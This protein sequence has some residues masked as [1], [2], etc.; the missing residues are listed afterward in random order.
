MT[1][2]SIYINTYANIL[3][4]VL[5]LLHN[6]KI[7]SLHNAQLCKDV[8]FL[9]YQKNLLIVVFGDAKKILKNPHK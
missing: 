9:I 4:T 1:N 7:T 2:V 5:I 6:L 3:V 8:Q